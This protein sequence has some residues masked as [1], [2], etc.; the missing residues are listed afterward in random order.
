MDPAGTE[1][2]AKDFAGRLD[3]EHLGVSAE[4]DFPT[5]AAENRVVCLPFLRETGEQPEADGFVGIVRRDGQSEPRIRQPA[6]LAEGGHDDGP[7]AA[8]GF[9]RTMIGGH[10]R[11]DEAGQGFLDFQREQ[12]HEGR[13]ARPGGWTKRGLLRIPLFYT[14][15]NNLAPGRE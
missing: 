2:G 7:I 11:Q 15:E 4:V 10:F 6:E 1:V 14:Y 5:V 13:F 3:R 8:R 12:S 9:F